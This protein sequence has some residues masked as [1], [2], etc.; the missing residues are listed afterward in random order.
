[1]TPPKKGSFFTSQFT[2]AHFEVEFVFILVLFFFASNGLK[3]N[4]TNALRQHRR[5]SP[6]YDLFVSTL[7]DPHSQLLLVH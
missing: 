3:T 1:M 7:R 4:E 5:D 2:K 6:C